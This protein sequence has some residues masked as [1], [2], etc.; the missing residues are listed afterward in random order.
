PSSTRLRAKSPASQILRLIHFLL[1]CC[2]RRDTRQTPDNSSTR[3]AVATAGEQGN[4]A[5]TV[6]ERAPLPHGRR[7]VALRS[8]EAKWGGSPNIRFHP[9]LSP[10]GRGR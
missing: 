5:A 9:K 4:R 8:R 10:A 3:P 1:F 6:R 7:S 2:G